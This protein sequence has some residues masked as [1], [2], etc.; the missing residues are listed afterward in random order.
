MGVVGLLW[1][2]YVLAVAVQPAQCP[3]VELGG[4]EN[5]VE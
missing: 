3:P 5:V 4:D 1:L 2:D